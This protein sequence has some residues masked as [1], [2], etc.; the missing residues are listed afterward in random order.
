MV[1]RLQGLTRI[2]TYSGFLSSVAAA[3]GQLVSDVP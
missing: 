1:I 3:H 2:N